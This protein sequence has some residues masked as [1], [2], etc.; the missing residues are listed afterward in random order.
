MAFQRSTCGFDG[1]VPGDHPRGLAVQDLAAP[2]HLVAEVFDVLGRRVKVL[3]DGM[4]QPGRN[5]LAVEGLSPGVYVV[6]AVVD[7]QVVTWRLT[8]L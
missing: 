7:G 3:A 5:V 2:A 6:R 8:V 4:R 1:P